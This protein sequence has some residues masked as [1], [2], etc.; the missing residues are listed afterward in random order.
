L[1]FLHE[2]QQ[3]FRNRYDEALAKIIFRM[4][5][6]AARALIN[7]PQSRRLSRR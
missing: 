3:I 5:H 4:T 1:Q 6:G 2:Y 7:I